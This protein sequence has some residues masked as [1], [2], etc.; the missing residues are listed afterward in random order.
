M[1]HLLTIRPH[2]NIR[3]AQ[4]PLLTLSPLPLTDAALP[5]HYVRLMADLLSGMGVPV[6]E[7]LAS[8]GLTVA[9]LADGQRGLGFAAFAKLAHDALARTQE[10]ALGLLVGERL[11]INTHGMLGYAAMNSSNLRQALGLLQT[12]LPLRTTMLRIE[13]FTHSTPQGETWEVHFLPAR[14]LGD[15]DTLVTEA[16]VLTIKNLIDQ[17]TFGAVQTLGASFR[18]AEPAYAPLARDMFGCE[19]RYGQE[20]S[21]LVLPLSALDQPLST[22]DPTT[23]DEAA[24]LCQQELD[25][26]DEGATLSIKVRRIMLDK[27]HGFPSLQVVARLFNMTP[28]TLHRRLLDEGS[29]YQQILDEVRQHLALQHLQA[30]KLSLQEIAFTLGYTEQANFRRAFKRWTGVAPSAYKASGQQG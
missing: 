26:R 15:I 21:G 29:A 20:W 5:M 28:R 16:V 23:F 11:R 18:H 1:G 14:D 30:G 24:R 13:Q 4:H 2:L 27:Q 17:I 8:A 3:S 25:K 12:F 10:P 19:V 9:D 22:A 7:L 6:P